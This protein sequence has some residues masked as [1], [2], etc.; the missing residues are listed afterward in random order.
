MVVF[1]FLA[2]GLSTAQQIHCC[3]RDPY[4]LRLAIFKP[5]VDS[6]QKPMAF[7][8]SMLHAHGY[9][10]RYSP[11]LALPAS[12]FSPHDDSGKELKWHHQARQRHRDLTGNSQNISCITNPE[13]VCDL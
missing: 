11:R 8:L 12:C 3:N 10:S 5:D 4:G 7:S 9:Y 13:N 2:L 1:R 6:D